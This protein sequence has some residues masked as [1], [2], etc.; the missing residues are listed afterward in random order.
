MKARRTPWRVAILPYLLGND[1]ALVGDLVE[2][3]PRRSNVWFWQ[4][5]M[6][7][8]LARTIRGA[9][10]TLREPHRLAGGLTHIAIVVV[11]SFQIAVA[12]SLLDELI[13]RVDQRL[14]TRLNHAEWLDLVVLLSLPAA[15]TFGKAIRHLH[16]RS[17][18]ATILACGAGATTVAWMTLSV[19]SSDTTGFF[20]PSAAHQ[21]AAAVVFVL[22][23]L[24]GGSRSAETANQPVSL[25]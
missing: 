19:L 18:A 13:R 12:G 21:T 20:L 15:W 8:T 16:R 25:R 22:A 2:E 7:A 1:Q 5:V 17:R 23:L 6:F 14:V 24:V 11:L 4:Q 10:A 9:S 3:W